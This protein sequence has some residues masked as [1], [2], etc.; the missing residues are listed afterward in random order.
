VKD[1]SPHDNEI[2][3]VHIFKVFNIDSFFPHQLS[4]IIYQSNTNWLILS[5][6]MY[7]NFIF[8][9]PLLLFINIVFGMVTIFII[10]H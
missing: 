4:F 5:Y 6:T 10:N 9:K 3:N 8:P 1:N 2:V 7:C